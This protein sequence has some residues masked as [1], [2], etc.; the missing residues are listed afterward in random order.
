MPAWARAWI[1]DTGALELAPQLVSDIR[2]MPAEAKAFIEKY[3]PNCLCRCDGCDFYGIVIGVISAPI[4][5]IVLLSEPGG[6]PPHPSPEEL[7]H[8]VGYRR[9]FTPEVVR[10]LTRCVGDA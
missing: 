3:P 1:D 10:M 9:G 6:T 8:I 4:G 2:S 7:V 5:K